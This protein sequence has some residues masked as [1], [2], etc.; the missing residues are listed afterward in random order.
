MPIELRLIRHALALGR[1]RNF[2]RAAEALNLT[3]PSLSRSI[4]ALE[5]A[6]EVPLFDR[7]QNG[8]TPTAF[9]R[10]LIEHGE[11]VLNREADLRREIQL[12]A[13]LEGGELSVGAGPYPSEISVA[14]AIA[15]IARAHPR[16]KIR[17]K[18]TD[19]AEVVRDVLAERID[20]GV[21]DAECLN[22]DH[23]LVIE[24][25][26]SHRIVLA[27]RPGHPLAGEARPTLA[28]VLEFPLVTTLLLGT[29]AAMAYNRST[30]EDHA[31]PAVRDFVPHILVNSLAIA[32]LIAR[33][34]DAIF[35]GT[36][37]MLAEDVAAGHLALV[38][39][40]M[41]TIKT[42]YGVLYL[43][44]RTLAPA[45]RV[46]IDSLHAVETEAH[47][48]DNAATSVAR[49]AAGTRRRARDQS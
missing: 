2:A 5:R 18:T 46:F 4:S 44:T 15:R 20:V 31:G 16:L 9:G 38:A 45:A 22:E 7:S 10:V 3:Q 34:S 27:C 6:L 11:T 26:P 23:R 49:R 33:D 24:P 37:S 42:H 28:R 13:G 25:L 30:P 29:A 43:R 48:A 12:L 35:P 39:F 14:T 19:P 32:R 41:P 47:R 1:Y 21:A 17:L 40:D 36:T 8:V